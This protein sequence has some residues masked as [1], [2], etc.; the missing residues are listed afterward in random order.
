M[1]SNEWLL[2]AHPT[3]LHHIPVE[4]NPHRAVGTSNLTCFNATCFQC[5]ALSA[6]DGA[7]CFVAINIDAIFSDNYSDIKI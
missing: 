6:A 4:M 5:L 7:N 3:T 2:T 1:L